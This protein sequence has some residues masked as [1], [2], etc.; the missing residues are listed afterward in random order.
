MRQWI[1]LAGRLYPRVWRERYGE[2][3]DALLEDAP[4]DWRQLRN[5]TRGALRMQLTRGGSYLKVAG[6]LALAGAILALAASYRVPARSVSSATLRLTPIP[7]ADQTV[8]PEVLRREADDRIEEL[9]ARAVLLPSLL[10]IAGKPELDLYRTRREKGADEEVARQ[11]RRDLRIETVDAPGQGIALRVSLA[12]PDRA[13]ARAAVSELVGELQESNGRLN[14]NS[15]EA[16]E[17]LMSDLKLPHG[18]YPFHAR[19]DL[20]EPASLPG[21]LPRRLLFVLLGIFGG[22]LVG[23]V[24]V[25]LVR[26]R[27]VAA[28]ALAGCAV[29][30]GLS[31]LVVERHTAIGTWR[32][33]APYDPLH[34]SGAVPT[35]PVSEWM[36]RLKR[37]VMESGPR[38]NR[39]L[40]AKK[41][42]KDGFWRNGSAGPSFDLRM[43][44]ST[45]EVRYSDPD[46]AKAQNLARVL[47]Y[48]LAEQ[49]EYDVRHDAEAAPGP[50]G[51]Y[52]RKIASHQELVKLVQYTSVAD[53]SV[54]HYRLE[55]IVAG[56]LLGALLPML[57]RRGGGEVDADAHQ[58]A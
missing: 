14:R 57:R 17:F 12:Y 35:V 45:F 26:H 54:T 3:F 37:E 56:A 22:I 31:L 38:P 11:I 25:L 43:R 40:L 6:G 5:V 19:L 55:L 2:E 9:K 18:Q 49:Y 50:N 29:G 30:A 52:L 33:T 58:F 1:A 23:M 36:T 51:E 48:L 24:S 32:I 44:D 16:W 7:A 47:G 20:S 27:R 53:E 10:E 34:A 41:L 15:A 4:A 21:T 42:E 46:P 8:T 13:K 28:C 39:L